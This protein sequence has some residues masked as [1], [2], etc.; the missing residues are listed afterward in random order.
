MKSE[1]FS[2]PVE[3]RC[4][5]RRS[6]RRH[7]QADPRARRRI[8]GAFIGQPGA[9]ASP[10]R[11][12]GLPGLAAGGLPR[13]ARVRAPAGEGPG[14]LTAGETP[15]DKAGLLSATFAPWN[16]TSGWR[17]PA[18]RDAV[19]YFLFESGRATATTSLPP[20]CSWRAAWASRLA[21]RRV[22]LPATTTPRRRLPRSRIG[23][24]F[25][26]ASLLP[27][28]RLDGLRADAVA[29]ASRVPRPSRAVRPRAT[30]ARSDERGTIVRER[31]ST[32]IWSVRGPAG[33]RAATS[34]GI[35]VWGRVAIAV[36][37]RACWPYRR[38]SSMC[39]LA[40][41][42]PSLSGCTRI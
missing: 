20:W 1:H 10:R 21:W 37:V 38:C 5:P 13:R 35:G 26:G 15:Y 17:L 32:R 12:Q 19:D 18:G 3:A 14:R 6:A 4:R 27:R 11:R 28:L 36:A 39:C 8:H 7:R 23:R 40:V 34:T 42:G 2:F 16:T 24:A 31:C 30:M 41:D 22:M 9:E 25:V 29:A 33:C